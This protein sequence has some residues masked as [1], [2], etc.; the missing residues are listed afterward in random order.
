MNRIFSL[1]RNRTL[2]GALP[3]TRLALSIAGA[4]ALGIV[5]SS[6]A[7]A[8]SAVKNSPGTQV[9]DTGSTGT[10]WTVQQG[11][12][13]IGDA[14]HQVTLIA[15][16]D[17][18]VANVQAGATPSGTD[19]LVVSAG[20]TLA[21]KAG[22]TGYL[23]EWY[24]AVP[25][26]GSNSGA[27]DGS[28]NDGGIG[29]GWAYSASG[30][31][32][33]G[34][35][36]AGSGGANGNNGGL[37]GSGGTGGGNGG[38]GAPAANNYYMGG[39]GGGGGGLADSG[40]GGGGGGGGGGYQWHSGGGGLGGG[41]G[42]LG[43]SLAADGRNEG[44][45]AG[46]AGS[47]ASGFT[48]DDISAGGGG[49]GAGALLQGAI[50]F[51]NGGSITGGAGGAGGASSNNGTGNGGGGGAAVLL[52]SGGGTTG[53]TFTNTGAVAGG[54][55]GAD[56]AGGTGTVFSQG[57]V[58]IATDG[59]ATVITSGSI[60]GGLS[61]DGVTRANA[62]YFTGGGNALTL[63]SGYTFVGNVVSASGSANGGDTLALGGSTDGTFN[64]AQIVAA[65]PGGW[66][67][68]AQYFGFNHFGKSGS[69]S[70]TVTGNAGAAFGGGI[71]VEDGTLQ[72]GDGT[73]T[74]M[75]NGGSAAVANGAM[76]MLSSTGTLATGGPLSMF[77][78]LGID[79]GDANSFG[80]LD[81]GGDA[82]F[83][84]GSAFSFYLDN[85]SNQHAGDTFEFFDA[86]SFLNFADASS[87]FNCSG[88]L[89]G[90]TCMLGMNGAGNGLVLTL[91]SSGTRS[92]PE[93]GSLGMLG[94]GLV[95]LGGGWRW[96][97]RRERKEA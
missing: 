24:G 13:Q 12:L 97:S 15:G 5:V 53:P 85:D 59:G 65:E 41:G 90:L 54:D 71:D 23:D 63:E 18:P 89:P 87:N 21:G 82:T 76:L 55:G 75:L 38:N 56:G 45:V 9:L 37:G 96:R 48:P 61:G 6:P 80:M 77:G 67:G 91:G 20:S 34:K 58:G 92:V 46:G 10:N 39:G 57:G 32:L 86:N 4:L 1:V 51:I 43:L 73:T 16:Y 44:T 11:T 30:S 40:V 35:G 84:V 94:L 78:E 79:I 42:G 17:G 8:G 66:N 93:P 19:A 36:A 14:S 25:G 26:R 72:V 83:G 81:V 33:D 68:N 95:L 31:S 69:S 64:L 50:G 28:A 88:L 47:D 7:R 62:A 27:T 52:T 49:G 60:A 70:W 3:K 2:C 29:G 22:L 74:A